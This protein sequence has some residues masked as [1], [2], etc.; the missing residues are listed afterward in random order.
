[1]TIFLIVLNVVLIWYI[2]GVTQHVNV[3]TVRIER[4]ERLKHLTPTL[5]W[6][7]KI[8]PPGQRGYTR[9]VEASSEG[10]AL[11]QLMNDKVKPTWI[12]SLIQRNGEPHHG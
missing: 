7:A 1:M 4:M 12:V 11:R 9:Q 6:E 10:D 2:R 5:Y 8:K 3:L